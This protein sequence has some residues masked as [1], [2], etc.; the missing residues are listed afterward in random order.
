[1]NHKGRKRVAIA[2]WLVYL[3]CT[4]MML[5]M[6][7]MNHWHQ[8]VSLQLILLLALVTTMTFVRSV[9][10]ELQA[11]VLMICAFAD[12]FTCSILEGDL[13]PSIIVILG[14]AVMISIYKNEKL[15]FLQMAFSVFLVAV[16]ILFLG[17]LDGQSSEFAFGFWVRMVVMIAAQFYLLVFIRMLNRSEESLR[18]SVVEARRAEHYKSDFL[19]NMSHEIRTPMNAIIGMCELILREDDLSESVRENCFNIQTAGRSLLEIIND[20]LDFSKI[21]SGK[22]ELIHDEFN[23]TSLLNDVINMS[24]ARKGDKKIEIIAGIDPDIPQGLIGDEVRIRQVM[25]NLMTNAI[26]FTE[27][28]SVTLY[29][30]YTHQEY[31]ANLFVS[32][33]DTGIGITEENIEKLFTSFRQVDTKKNRAVEGTG[34]GLAISKQMIQAM[35]GFMSVKSEYGKGSEFRF[36]IP[37]EISDRTP[38]VKI[39]EPEKIHAVACLDSEMQRGYYKKLFEEIGGKFGIDFTVC[40]RLKELE[41]LTEEKVFTHCF[42]GQGKYIATPDYFRALA[43][44]TELFVIQDRHDNILLPGQIKCLYKPFYVLALAAALNNENLVLNLNSHRKQEMHFV[45]P[46]ARILIVDDNAINL[47]VAAGLMRPYQMQILTAESGPEAISMLRSKDIDLVFMDH[48]M[49]QMDGVEATRIIRDMPDA[50]YKELPIIALTANAVNGVRECFIQA[51]FDDFLAK[52]IELNALDRILRYYLPHEY[53]QRPVELNK[54][55][56]EQIQPQQMNKNQ[57][58]ALFDPNMGLGYTGGDLDAYLDILS[59][60]AKKGEEKLLYIRELAQKNDMQNYIIEVHA[61]KSTSLSIGAASLSE[62]AKKLEMACKA[63]NYQVIVSENENLLSLYK[64]VIDT[65]T[66][67]LEQFGDKM[68]EQE[69]EP[70]NLQEIDEE[71]LREAISHAIEACDGFDAD[72][73]RELAQQMSGYTFA[74][75]RLREY[76]G[77][78]AGLSEDFEYDEAREIILG[79][80]TELQDL[81]S[82]DADENT[83]A[84]E[85]EAEA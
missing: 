44:K 81:Q 53:L 61:L 68:D 4:L 74:G 73:M 32:V 48:M 2:A 13:Y 18:Q 62:F 22:M 71:A 57:S 33:A 66:G 72:G 65:V 25:I 58:V 40:D 75:R 59:L 3:M 50:Y 55:D 64:N 7:W 27:K 28:G 21:E 31:G 5:G 60:Y 17:T 83:A 41:H 8:S 14:E 54:I 20:I 49:P 35:G 51:G 36:V 67:Y 26:K 46:K 70:V 29:V 43:E 38:F 84:A 63:G 77:K 45:A 42:V 6:T 79:L 15:L 11:Y 19:A 1:M 47:K 12:I 52:P 34:L 9:S 39:R 30:T 76:F 56:S 23:I 16:H 24:M 78:A 37:L 85:S 69:D 80:E 10:I 82:D